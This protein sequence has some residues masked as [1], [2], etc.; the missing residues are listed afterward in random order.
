MGD[1][2]FNGG[3]REFSGAKAYQTMAEEIRDAFEKGAFADVVRLMDKHFGMHHYSLK[4][5][6]KDEQRKNPNPDHQGAD[7]GV[8]H[9]LSAD[10]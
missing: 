10:V 9:G 5:L 3:V 6:F 8:C 2:A 4:D 7:G 1:H